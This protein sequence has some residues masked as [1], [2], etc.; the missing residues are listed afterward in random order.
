MSITACVVSNEAYAFPGDRYLE[1]ATESVLDLSLPVVSTSR[2][3]RK[4]WSSR[5]F[6]H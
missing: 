5:G 6:E 1:E 4:S 3:C 2:F